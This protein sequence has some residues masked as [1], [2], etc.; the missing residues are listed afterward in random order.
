MMHTQVI[1]ETAPVPVVV[2]CTVEMSIAAGRSSRWPR[3]RAEY[4]KENPVCACC[5]GRRLLTVHHVKPFHVFPEMELDP[6]NLITLCEG[7]NGLN[8]HF[9]IGHC[10]DWKA[11]NILVRP[12]AVMIG[13]MLHKRSGNAWR[14][15][16][17]G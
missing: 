5:G 16:Q 15:R 6:S 7:S 11:W 12:D 10:G 1:E 9:W 8:C 14:E 4:V 17:H 3:V 2:P 13:D